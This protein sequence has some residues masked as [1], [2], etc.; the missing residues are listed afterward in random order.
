MGNIICTAHKKERRIE[1]FLR[2]N[3]GDGKDWRGLN[4]ADPEAERKEL[5]R[6]LDE[7]INVVLGTE[8]SVCEPERWVDCREVL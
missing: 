8:K 7:A 3:F 1:L 5:H 2:E 6:I 4:L